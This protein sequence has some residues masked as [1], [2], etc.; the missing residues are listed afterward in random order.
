MLAGPKGI[1]GWVRWQGSRLKLL[2]GL[3]A[4]EGLGERHAALGAEVVAV[5]P[6]HTAKGMVSRGEGSERGAASSQ[7]SPP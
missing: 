6:A 4:L 5:E 1:D 3:V 2:E 7:A